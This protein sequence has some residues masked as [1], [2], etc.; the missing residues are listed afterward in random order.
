MVDTAVVAAAGGGA[1]AHVFDAVEAVTWQDT[2][3]ERKID[4]IDH[5]ACVA[6]AAIGDTLEV[7]CGVAHID[8]SL[9]GTR[10][11]ERPLVMVGAQR[12]CC[13][14]VT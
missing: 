2:A 1:V 11:V 3:V 12:H 7:A 5:V 6:G 4:G 8:H 10:L 14:H 13:G 9:G